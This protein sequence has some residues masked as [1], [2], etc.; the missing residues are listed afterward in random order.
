MTIKVLRLG[1]LPESQRLSPET[2]SGRGAQQAAKPHQAIAGDPARFLHS[3]A[4]K[5]V[6]LYRRAKAV[7]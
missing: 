6:P 7:W 5:W 1:G 3:F 2:P 4:A